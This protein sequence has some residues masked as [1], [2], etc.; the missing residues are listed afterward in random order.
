MGFSGLFE[1]VAVFIQNG[2]QRAGFGDL[3]QLAQN[4]GM[5]LPFEIVQHRNQHEDDV[6]R[7]SLKVGDRQIEF[8]H[9]NGG[10]NVSIERGRFK[11][12]GHVEP[13]D[14]IEHH[15]KPGAAGMLGHVV[16]NGLS[17]VMDRRRAEFFDQG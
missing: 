17:L 15:L 1:R 8:S 14:R 5:L 7:Q 13:T 6:Q 4:R 12:L 2:L 3:G 16:L 11:R 9:G 10:S